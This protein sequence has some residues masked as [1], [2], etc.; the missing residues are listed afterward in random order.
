MILTGWKCVLETKLTN[1]RHQD[2]TSRGY[3]SYE[4][5]LMSQLLHYL[6]GLVVFASEVRKD[7]QASLN[8]V[9]STV[10]KLIW[11][12]WSSTT[13]FTQCNKRFPKRSQSTLS[14]STLSLV[15]FKLLK[16]ATYCLVAE[17]VLGSTTF[18]A[19]AKHPTTSYRSS[20]TIDNIQLEASSWY[21]DHC[22]NL[23]FF[24]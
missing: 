3:V 21:L 19:L 11:N 14:G 15:R 16:R 7:D 12:T 18:N 20:R 6:P 5:L 10:S 17:R 22:T 13:W 1:F 23:C 4:V 24:G 2:L 9:M 8:F